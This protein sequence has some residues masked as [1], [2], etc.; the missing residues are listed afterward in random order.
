MRAVRARMTLRVDP[1]RV[2][3]SAKGSTGRPEEG[4]DS[5]TIS[6][7]FPKKPPDF[8][9]ADMQESCAVWRSVAR[10][11]ALDTLGSEGLACSAGH[12]LALLLTTSRGLTLSDVEHTFAAT[13]LSMLF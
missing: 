11:T 7:S 13:P 6:P 10:L 8:S 4:S 5:M 2:S 12:A 3:M 1:H 9:T